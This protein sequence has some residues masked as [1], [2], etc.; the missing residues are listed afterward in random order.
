[1]GS[2]VSCHPSYHDVHRDNTHH[3]PIG[4]KSLNLLK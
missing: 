1:M 3:V 4:H 2:F